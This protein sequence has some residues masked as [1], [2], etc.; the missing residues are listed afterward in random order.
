[1]GKITIILALLCVTTFA[2]QRGSFTDKRDGKT[3]KTTKIGSQIWMAEN[4]DYAARNSKCYKN[5]ILYCDRYGRLY[6]WETAMI[7]CP[8]GWHLPNNAE[9]GVL[10]KKVESTCSSSE[11]CISAGQ[12]LKAKS[13]WIYDYVKGTDTFG[14]AALPSGAG[15][16]D[17]P[18]VGDTEFSNAGSTG[19]W[20][21]A[22]VKVADNDYQI[23]GGADLIY[24]GRGKEGYKP[25]L[26]SVR[27]VKD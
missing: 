1:M 18:N 27:C 19:G 23:I 20:W 12:L 9:W 16:L 25:A 22:S 13:D 3:Y 26:Y 24:S 17:Y 14:F 15:L 11:N 5:E 8:K 6:D 2:Q 4:M 10:K 7:V 21:S